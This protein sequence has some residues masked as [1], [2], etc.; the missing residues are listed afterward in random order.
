[1]HLKIDRGP[2]DYFVG[3]PTLEPRL[4]SHF[5]R[6]LFDADGTLTKVHNKNRV[7][8]VSIATVSESM[9]AGIREE[10]GLNWSYSYGHLAMT[11]ERARMFLKRIYA[12]SDGLFLPRKH[13]IYQN[14]MREK[15]HLFMEV[16]HG[17]TE[18]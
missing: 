16:A 7:L 18:F 17:K 15:P 10:T 5:L 4:Y 6:G 11:G 1:M 12:D 2:K 13:D 9:V 14:W 3:F 8:Y